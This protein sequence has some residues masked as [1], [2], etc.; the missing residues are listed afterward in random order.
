MRFFFKL[1]LPLKADSNFKD[2]DKSCLFYLS[3]KNQLNILF[4]Q[5]QP[6]KFEKFS[7]RIIFHAF[8]FQEMH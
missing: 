8:N 4:D 3:S 2:L 6:W 1:M 5:L 7:R